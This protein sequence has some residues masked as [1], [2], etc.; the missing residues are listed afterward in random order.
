MRMMEQGTEVGGLGM[1]IFSLGALAILVTIA[2]YTELKEKRIPNFLTL[3][4][5]LA[6][7][8]VGYL[9][10]GITLRASIAGLLTGFG[11]LFIFYVFGGIGGGDVKLMGAVG[12]LLGYP[13]ILPAVFFTA[14]IG[15][16]MAVMLLI[17]KGE[18]W[19]SGRRCLSL[20]WRKTEADTA[21]APNE[22]LTIP[23][24]VAIAIG[25]LLS[26]FMGVR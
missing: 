26:L 9:P 14:I 5:M 3:L 18:F 12:A 20:L 15:G 1:L 17:W 6:G 8:A 19:R 25:S 13:M 7:L 22:P 10:G 21:P 16:F 2:V 11:F 24:G 4:G 23:Y